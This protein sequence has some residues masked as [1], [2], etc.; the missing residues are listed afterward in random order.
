MRVGYGIAHPEIIKTLYKLR[1]PFNITTLSLAAC[2]EALKDET[3]VHECIAKNF[4]QMKQYE[5]YAKQKGLEYIESYTNFITI[6]LPLEYISAQVAQLLLEKGVIIRDLTSY[7][8]NAIRITIGTAT[9][10]EKVLKLLDETLSSLQNC[11]EYD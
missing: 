9:Q 10:N 7:G 6:K 2:I 3:F 4:E 8:L 11:K 1:P 5:V